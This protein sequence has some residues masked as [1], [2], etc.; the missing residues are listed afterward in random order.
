MSTARRVRGIT[1]VIAV[2]TAG[3]L[4]LPSASAVPTAD[5]DGFGKDAWWYKAMGLAEAHKISTGKGVTIAVIDGPVDPTVPELKGRDVTIVKSFCSNL[6]KA[7]GPIASHGTNMVVNIVGNGKGTLSG[8]G[9]VVGVAPDASVRTYSVDESAERGLQCSVANARAAAFD[10]AISDQVDIISYSIGGATEALA[11]TAAVSKAMAAGIVVVA[12]SGNAPEDRSVIYPAF[13]PGVVAV[14]AADK[15]AKPCS[16]TVEGKREAF[17]IGAPGADFPGGG[18]DGNRWRSDG[19]ASGSS[20]ATS[21]VAGGLALVAAK[22]PDATGNQLIQHLIHNP[23]G[24]RTFGRDDQFGYGI[25]S[26]PKMLAS[27]PEQWPDTNPLVVTSP[28][29]FSVPASAPTSGPD[30]QLAGSAAEDNGGGSSAGLIFGGLGGFVILAGAVAFAMSRR[31][32][33]SG[34]SSHG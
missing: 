29:P 24:S 7:T 17:V 14:V 12:A 20:E 19:I 10:A 8:G 26:V 30:T 23:G 31:K 32:A 22:Y 34:R 28:Q 21:V 6:P 2:A 1:V 13:I 15:N 9:G 27:D 16:C 3:A 33:A 18:F 11:E 5:A 4:A 25:M